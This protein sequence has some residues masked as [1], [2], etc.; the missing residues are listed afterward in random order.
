M[1]KLAFTILCC[2]AVTRAFSKIDPSLKSVLKTTGTASI[3]ISFNGGTQ[4]VLDTFVQQKFETRADKLTALSLVLQQH[5]ASVQK[6]VLEFLQNNNEFSVTSFW[7][8]NQV[9]VK[10]A[11]L[12]LVE[13]LATFPEVAEIVE[14]EFFEIDVPVPS[15][16][17]ES[18]GPNAVEWGVEK[19][20]AP[21]AWAIG[22]DGKGI[23]VATVDTG[24]LVEHQDLK[25]NFVGDYGWFDPGKGTPT[26]NDNNGHGTHTTGTICGQG[27]K[28][29]HT[30]MIGIRDS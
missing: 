13:Q 2:I 24:V 6:N 5:S 19:V 22:N 1:L 26:P 18:N 11:D 27:M 20:E 9:Y 15:E 23:V 12:S 10:N 16:D 3:F 29:L 30:N 14:E 17:E 4:H 8:N 21:G 7:I 28:N 25:D